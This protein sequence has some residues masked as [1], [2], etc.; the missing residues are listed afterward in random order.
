MKM[1]LK[2]SWTRNLVHFSVFYIL[3]S[4]LFEGTA[5]FLLFLILIWV[6]YLFL[7]LYF[8]MY[9]ERFN[10]DDYR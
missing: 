4:F 9:E 3:S 5:I 2:K 7:D 1:R 10:Q 6:A 8:F